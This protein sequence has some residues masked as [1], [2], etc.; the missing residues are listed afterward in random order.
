MGFTNTVSDFKINTNSDFLAKADAFKPDII[1]KNIYPERAVKIVKNNGDWAVVQAGTVAETEGCELGK[2]SSIC[3]DFGNHYVG[4]IDFDVNYSKNPLDAPLYLKIKLGEKPFEIGEESS[5]YHG[6]LGSGWIQEEYIHIDD[7]PAHIDFPRRY[8]FRYMQI[9]VIDTSASYKVNIQNVRCT[10]V[11]S[12]DMSAVVKLKLKDETLAAI[13][14]VSVKTMLE[15]MQDV[16]EDGPK[17]DRRLWVGD[18]RL[19]A[20]VN[21]ETF[22]NYD[23]VKRCLYLVAGLTQGKGRISACVYAKRKSLPSEVN[24]FDYSLLY[25]SC[26]YD[27]YKQTSDADTVRDLLPTAKRQI[28]LAAEKFDKR[29]IIRDSSEWWCFI[30]WNDDLNKQASAQAIFI[31]CAKQYAELAEAF[32]EDTERVM[33]LID[34][35]AD[36]AKQYLW[37]EERGFFVSGDTKQI[38]WASQ[39]WFVLSGILSK[40]ENAALL[41]RLMKVN[42]QVGLKTPYAY[43]Y[44]IQA[45]FDSGMENYAVKCIKKYWGAMVDDGADCFYEIFNPENI[46][47]SPYGSRVI[48]SYCHSWSGTPAYFIRKYLEK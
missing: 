44:F 4:Y 9:T 31:Y 46:S 40:E 26:L 11:T 24:L 23:L 43:H 2:N 10:S 17:R 20:L 41:E 47:Y 33:Q 19:Q 28:E 37:R 18:L 14:R 32:G 45:L 34:M 5:D 16:F 38:S 27:Y 15:C 8:A 6:V 22:K 3:Y 36:A 13:D 48:N 1:K 7:L 35:A 21:Y 30:D 39:I 12:A 25:I 42:P 29:G